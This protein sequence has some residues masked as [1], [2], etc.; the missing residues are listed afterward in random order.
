MKVIG[1]IQPADFS[2]PSAQEVARLIDQINAEH[3]PAIFG[4]RCSRARC[5]R[6]SQGDRTRSTRTRCDDDDLPGDP[7]QDGPQLRGL[8]LYDVR[9]CPRPGRRSVGARFRAAS[10]TAT[11]EGTRPCTIPS[12]SSGTSPSPTARTPSSTRL[13][14]VDPRGGVRR[15]GGAER[16]RQEHVPAARGGTAGRPAE[17]SGSGPRD[18]LAGGPARRR[19]PDSRRSTG[20]SPSRSRRSCC[21]GA[22]PTGGC[23]RGRPKATQGE[24]AGRARKLGIGDLARRHIRNLGRPAAAGVH[25]PGA[26]PPA[27]APPAR[28]ADERRR[29][30]DA[31][32]R[33]APAA[34]AQPRGHRDRDHDPRP[35]R[36]RRAPPEPDLPEPAG[37][38]GR[39][40]EEVLTSSTSSA[41]CTGPRWS[42]WSADG[43]L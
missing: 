36:G 40:P 23:C 28:R 33:P 32:R 25:R 34:H 1:A 29:C 5:S 7:G 9:R 14:V 43:M 35:Q 39:P 13:N 41:S 37:G 18:R 20:T 31:P 2:E 6:R 4:R 11:T 8:M 22:P 38:R 10:P 27:A 42:S 15:R 30:R 26:D 21:S 17:R 12:S 16:G 3:V 19:P 24:G